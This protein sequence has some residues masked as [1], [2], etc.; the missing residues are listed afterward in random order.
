VWLPGISN[1]IGSL[2]PR[3][4]PLSASFCRGGRTSALSVNIGKY[5]RAQAGRSLRAGGSLDCSE[6][7]R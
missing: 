1:R 7:A 2:N 4:R 3:T 6:G 5:F